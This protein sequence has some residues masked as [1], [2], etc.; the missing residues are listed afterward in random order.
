[1]TSNHGTVDHVQIVLS[2]HHRKH[3]WHRTLTF[4]ALGASAVIPV[5]HVVLAKGIAYARQQVSL[6]LVVAG[7]AAYI[8]GAVL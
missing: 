3:R 8:F 5:A 1:M 6:D 7:G 2:P 4:I